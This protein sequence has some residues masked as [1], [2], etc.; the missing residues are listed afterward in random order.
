VRKKRPI[1][2]QI[3]KT[4]AR[5]YLVTSTV[6]EWESY[7]EEDRPPPPPTTIRKQPSTQKDLRGFF[8]PKH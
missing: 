3:A 5:G 7:S 1:K 4:D 8:Q 6:T 2:K